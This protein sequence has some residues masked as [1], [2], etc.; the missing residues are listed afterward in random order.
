MKS[1][2][3]YLFVQIKSFKF[4][5]LFTILGNIW[6]FL[7]LMIESGSHFSVPFANYCK[8]NIVE[9]ISV[10]TIIGIVFSICV[11]G[12]RKHKVKGRDI[13][14]AIKMCNI[15]KEKEDIVIPTNTSF[16]T[17][18]NLKI[19]SRNSLQGKFTVKYFSN[20]VIDLDKTIKLDLESLSRIKFTTKKRGN[21]Y[22]YDIGTTAIV[23]YQNDRFA[24]FFAC[25]EMNED[26]NA[27]T[28]KEI[29]M[30]SLPKLWETI[31]SRGNKTVVNIPL[32]GTGFGRIE[33][34]SEKVAKL[35]IDS[36]LSALS[37]GNS[38]VTQL[39]LILYPFDVYNK[40]INI[41]TLCN[42][43]EFHC[44]NFDYNSLSGKKIGTGIV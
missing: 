22:K 33:I 18:L 4:E 29:I 27:S 38:L 15:L 39:N 21:K 31:R 20:N 6:S 7:W 1:L 44:N 11:G 40:K 37:T 25:C 10:C 12:K 41:K 17:A 34:E 28:N 19:I 42:Y 9:I 13:N 3:Y 36:F 2:Y 24:Y 5:L 16:D 43:I 35:I 23:N 8:Q 14:I 30:Q 26:C 32:V